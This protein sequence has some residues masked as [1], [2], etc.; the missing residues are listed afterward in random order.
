MRFR[1][2]RL[3]APMTALNAKINANCHAPGSPARHAA[4]TRNVTK[5]HEFCVAASMER[6]FPRKVSGTKIV[7]HGSQALLEM[8]RER[9]KQKSKASM[10]A[11]RVCESRN[12][13]VKGTAAM[14][15][16]K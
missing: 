8:P 11:K 16:M 5:L 10:R 3:M 7:I 12:V 13:C 2:V 6:Y 14:A 9:L 1:K 15:K 4:A